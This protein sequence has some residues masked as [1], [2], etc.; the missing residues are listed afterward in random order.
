LGKIGINSP[1]IYQFKT[2][3]EH[4]KE[5]NKEHDFF[6]KAE[7]LRSKSTVMNE[8]KVNNINRYENNNNNKNYNKNYNN[9][10]H[11]NYYCHICRTKG[12][13]TDHCKYNLLIKKAINQILIFF[14]VKRIKILLKDI[15]KIIITP[16][17][18]LIIMKM[19]IIKI[20]IILFLKIIMMMKMKYILILQEIFH[21]FKIVIIQQ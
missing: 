18:L 17:I 11:N 10:F 5:L 21:S 2:F 14:S 8:I 12:H 7:I 9:N 4:I 19:K 15:I 6:E 16:L 13:S 1:P 20:T 3:D